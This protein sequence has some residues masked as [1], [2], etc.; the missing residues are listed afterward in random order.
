VNQH[1]PE[2][3]DVAL[4]N[5]ACIGLFAERVGLPLLPW[6]QRVIDAAVLER[7]RRPAA[8]SGN[9]VQ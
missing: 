9:D 7:S 5:A 3:V 1:D 8:E 4:L 6:Q 2:A